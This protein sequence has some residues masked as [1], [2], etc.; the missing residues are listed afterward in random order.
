MV[1]YGVAVKKQMVKVKK[2]I[3]WNF[4]SGGDLG[5]NKVRT[6]LLRH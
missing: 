4:V 6:I 1:V 5:S 2:Q 3:C